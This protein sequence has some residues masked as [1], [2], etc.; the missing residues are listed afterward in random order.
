MWRRSPNASARGGAR[1]HCPPPTTH[2]PNEPPTVD[3]CCVPRSYGRIAFACPGGQLKPLEADVLAAGHT[4]I[5][6]AA[7]CAVLCAPM[8]DVLCWAVSCAVMS[9]CCQHGSFS[10]CTSASSCGG[11]RLCASPPTPRPPP[12]NGPVGGRPTCCGVLCCL[13]H[14]AAARASRYAV[15]S[16]TVLCCPVLRAGAHAVRVAADAGQGGRAGRHPAGPRRPR[17][18]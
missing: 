18:G 14:R 9:V 4:V 12:L 6:C 10:L 17:G 16:C 1:S 11:A 5:A 2:R 8:S 3:V 15:L 13:L 7:C